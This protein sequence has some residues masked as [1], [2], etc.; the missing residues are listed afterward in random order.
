MSNSKMQ[1]FSSFTGNCI[2]DDVTTVSCS[3][4]SIELGNILPAFS[5]A[6]AFTIVLSRILFVISWAVKKIVSCLE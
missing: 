4:Y 1:P 3:V 2:S 6:A 5:V